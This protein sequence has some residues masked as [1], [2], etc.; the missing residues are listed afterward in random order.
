MY[1]Y[2]EENQAQNRPISGYYKKQVE[3]KIPSL[4][5]FILAKTYIIFSRRPRRFF[6]EA[7][8]F[9]LL[10]SLPYALPFLFF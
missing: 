9:L 7:H 6:L 8:E 10:P 4:G 5:N 2:I 1:N 3:N